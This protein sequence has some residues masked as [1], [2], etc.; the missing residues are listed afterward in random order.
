MSEDLDATLL[1][2]Q[3]KCLEWLL[4]RDYSQRTLR[5]YSLSL[6]RFRFWVSE[7]PELD[8]LSDLTTEVITNF[9][10]ELSLTKTKQG[11]S[12]QESYLSTSYR[13]GVISALVQF[14]A[15]LHKRGFILVN[16]LHEVERPFERRGL[17]RCILTVEEVLRI[18]AC[19]DVTGPVG[20]RNRAALELIYTAGL[21][22]GEIQSINLKD[23]DL[24]ERTLLVHGK[25]NLKRYVPM[26]REAQKCLQSYLLQGRPKFRAAGSKALFLSSRRGRMNI[27]SLRHSYKVYAR[28]AGITKPVDLHGLRHTC[29][30]HMLANGADIRYIQT[31]LGHKS[32]KSTQIYTRVE[33]SGLKNVLDRCHPRDKF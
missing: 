17:P 33:I 16:P 26:G 22:S 14:F 2:Q 11:R 15:H 29:A 12:G 30:T 31:L 25:G 27:Q 10:V 9:L 8:D 18:L 24:P 28:K 7:Q 13:N 5:T 21:R 19:I 32:L 20:L 23:L 3:Y 4:F 1:E 6:K